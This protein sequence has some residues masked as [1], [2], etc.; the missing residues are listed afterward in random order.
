MTV[1][2][3]TAKTVLLNRHGGR[4]VGRA[5]W[6]GSEVGDIDSAARAWR[7]GFGARAGD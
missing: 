5:V 2:Y 1:V 4:W 7:A 3:A 6:V